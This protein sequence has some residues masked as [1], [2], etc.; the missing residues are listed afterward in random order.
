MYGLY[1]SWVLVSN[2]VRLVSIL[3]G[4]IAT[5]RNHNRRLVN[6]GF[7]KFGEMMAQTDDSSLQMWRMVVQ[8]FKEDHQLLIYIA[9]P[10]S[11]NLADNWGSLTLF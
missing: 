4:L 10:D 6:S 7:E 3:S 2:S 1:R 11:E 8:N 5:D 9:I